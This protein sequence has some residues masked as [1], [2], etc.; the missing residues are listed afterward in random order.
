MLNSNLVKQVWFQSQ[1]SKNT[2]LLV[3]M[4]NQACFSFVLIILHI[5][6]IYSFNR[7][8]FKTCLFLKV[9]LR[10]SVHDIGKI[11]LHQ[12]K[13][14]FSTEHI[15]VKVFILVCQLFNSAVLGQDFLNDFCPLDFINKYWRFF[16][17]EQVII[18]L[19]QRITE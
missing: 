11:S 13:D 19:Q 3:T 12:F 15:K 6:A 8:I 4:F 5:H 1:Q 7:F 9:F 18:L 17:P 2:K 16:V 10:N 14:S